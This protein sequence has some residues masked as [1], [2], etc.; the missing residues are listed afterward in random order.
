MC[1]WSLEA[2]TYTPVALMKARVQFVTLYDC[3][4]D[5][6]RLRIYVVARYGENR[7]DR[8]QLYEIHQAVF[9]S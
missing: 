6:L 7:A 8:R 5:I 4:Q 9:H 2:L 3:L 1:G